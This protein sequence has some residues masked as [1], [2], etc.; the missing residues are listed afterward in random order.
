[1]DPELVWLHDAYGEHMLHWLTVV[2]AGPEVV[3]D[4]VQIMGLIVLPVKR[5]EEIE[6]ELLVVVLVVVEEPVDP[7]GGAGVEPVEAVSV[8]GVTFGVVVVG[9]GLCVGPTGLAVDVLDDKVVDVVVEVDDED[10]ELVVV[11]VEV[12]VVLVVDKVVVELVV[13][14]DFVGTFGFVVVVVVE[15]AV[16]IEVGVVVT[17]LGMVE[18]SLDETGA[19]VTDVS[20]RNE[21][22]KPLYNK[23]YLL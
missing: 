3:V 20:R 13:A 14:P 2:V 5:A 23:I 8:G 4:T 10:D 18:G 6:V 12:V 15:V 11:D 17:E 9:N 21:A 16:V 1:M 7:T 22:H 19:P